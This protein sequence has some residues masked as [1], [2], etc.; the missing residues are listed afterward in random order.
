[1]E[2]PIF[3]LPAFD[4]NACGIPARIGGALPFFF[5]GEDPSRGW[6]LLA[7]EGDR[8]EADAY[9][10]HL[11]AAACG[12]APVWSGPGHLIIRSRKSESFKFF[13]LPRLEIENARR[14][15]RALLGDFSLAPDLDHLPLGMIL[16]L[17]DETD[18]SRPKDGGDW[19]EAIERRET[20]DAERSFMLPGLR[21][22]TLRA[23][24]PKVPDDAGA[25][26]QR[27][28]LPF[29]RW[30]DAWEKKP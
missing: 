26:I 18:P 8:A 17:G 12:G 16:K 20:E 6:S 22:R 27:R 5:W 15:L 7:D 2:A 29:L 11:C 28:L 23:L 9:V 21:A 10:L 25:K 1:L 24:T 13:R 4:G 3:S 19:K 30:K 14:D